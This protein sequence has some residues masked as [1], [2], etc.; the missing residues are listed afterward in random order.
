[1]TP[2]PTAAP[3]A[4]PVVLRATA[5]GVTPLEVVLQVELTG[6]PDLRL[7]TASGLLTIDATAGETTDFKFQVVN[8]GGGSADNAR[9]VTSVP[10]GWGIKI[11]NNPV[12]RIEAGGTF[13]VTVSVTPPDKTVPGD[14]DFQLIASVGGQSTGLMVSVTVVRSTMFAVLGVALIG[15]VALGLGGLFVRLTRP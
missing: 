9:F 6:V 15:V 12:P 7:T 2:P 11:D 13:E 1:V 4:H 5:E 10:P 3:G 14:Y 8:S